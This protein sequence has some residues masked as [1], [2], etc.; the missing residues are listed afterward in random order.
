MS[1]RDRLLPWAGLLLGA[2]GWAVSSQWGAARVSD[3]CLQAWSWQTAILGIAGLALAAVGAWFSWIADRDS[4]M[5]TARFIARLSIAA[6]AV[7][8]LAILLHTA[9]SLM[10]PR[11]FS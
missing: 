2:S 11:C 5:P 7:F 3:A 1:G 9:A 10:I 6:A 8:A 4:T